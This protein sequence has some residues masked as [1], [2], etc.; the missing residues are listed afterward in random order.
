MALAAFNQPIA[1]TAVRDG[2]PRIVIGMS[3]GSGLVFIAIDPEGGVERLA[4][5]EFTFDV[6]WNGTDW[7]D[8]EDGDD[9]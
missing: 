8:P 2:L 3:D 9:D 7:V 5:A 1:A 6:R 4:P